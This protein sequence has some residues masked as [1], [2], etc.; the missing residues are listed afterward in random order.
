[1]VSSGGPPDIGSPDQAIIA[2]VLLA[3]VAV[4]WYWKFAD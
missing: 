4:I 3:I 2:I 1:M